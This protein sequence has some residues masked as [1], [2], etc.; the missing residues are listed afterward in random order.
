[1][2]LQNFRIGLRLTIGFAFLGLLLVVQGVSALYSMNSMHKITE[3]VDKNTIPGLERLAELNLNVMRMRVYTLRLLLAENEEQLQAA[4]GRVREI[5]EHIATVRRQY[6]PLIMA[7]DEQA[8]Y[9]QFGAAYL[10]YDQLKA[11]LV[12]LVEANRQ[13]EA[14]ELANTLLADSAGQMEKNLLHLNGLV[15]QHASEQAELSEQSYGVSW[16]YVIGIVLV[17]LVM[18]LFASVVLSRSIVLPVRRAV[19]L[20]QT[21][22]GGDLTQRI[23]VSGRDE[24]AELAQAM[25]VMQQ[26]L[27]DTI[28]HIAASAQTLASASEELNTVTD[29]AAISMNRQNDEIRQASAAI[30]EMSAA[31]EEVA[32]T[33]VATSEASVQSAQ[34]V[35]VSKQQVGFT[36]TAIR[37][38]NNDMA[39]SAGLVG[40]LAEQSQ[41]IGK[42]LDVIRAIAEQTN[43][44]ALNAAIEAARAGD[45]GRGFAVVADEVRALAHRTQSSTKEI[46]WMVQNI[47]GGTQAAVV[48]MEHSREKAETALQQAHKAGD[49]LELIAQQINQIRDSNHFIASAAEQQA[50]AARSMD[51]NV[52]NMSG[53]ADSATACA[54]ETNAAAHD[55]SRLA[56]DLNTLVV[57][58]IV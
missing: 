16:N 39:V 40:E 58:F 52:S 37:D 3:S 50:K 32:Y 51:K 14:T 6:E 33:A 49:A 21:V 53:L 55:L 30:T 8:S 34:S 46:E 2:Q 31:V 44:L 48:S 9:D 36:V 10:R 25:Q 42:V 5:H 27:R 18:A 15:T 41:H 11:E 13:Q 19:R 24:M 47:R 20:A 45:A 28:R 56:V 17:S 26:N 7:A 29:S 38:I 23:E 12:T 54:Q 4:K 22:A 1:M 57:R 43:L 35:Q